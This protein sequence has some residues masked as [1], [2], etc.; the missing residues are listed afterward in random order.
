MIHDGRVQHLNGGFIIGTGN[1]S[2]SKYSSTAAHKHN[3][4]VLGGKITSAKRTP[5][6]RALQKLSSCR[7]DGRVK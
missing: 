6:E 4:I 7:M 1:A 3:G 5:S 2:K